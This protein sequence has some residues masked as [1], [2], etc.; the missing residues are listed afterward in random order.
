M[1]PERPSES[2][3]ESWPVSRPDATQDAALVDVLSDDLR[4]A[5]LAAAGLVSSG[6]RVD[7][8]GL[9]RAVGLLC[10]KTLDL[11]PPAGRAAR[12]ALT[13]LAAS[14]GALDVA[15]RVHPPASLR[16]KADPCQ[17]FYKPS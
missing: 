11:P 10:A 3:P 15:L 5:V 14:I 13:S 17:P 4:R 12:D 8:T 6:Q 7:V 9:D 16:Q 1:V 2:W